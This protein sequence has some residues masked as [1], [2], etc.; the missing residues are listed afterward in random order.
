MRILWSERLWTWLA[1]H[2]WLGSVP[3]MASLLAY[4]LTHG[5]TEAIVAGDSML[6]ALMLTATTMIDLASIQVH[7]PPR[8]ILWSSLI[9]L[10][11]ACGWFMLANQYPSE[12]FDIGVLRS[13]SLWLLLG[14]FV[15]ALG[16][17]IYIETISYKSAGLAK[18]GTS[19]GP[20]AERAVPEPQ[21][22]HEMGADQIPGGPK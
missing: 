7:G 19:V 10:G 3:F 20:S 11:W 5:K 21:V 17:Q 1:V 16:V 22:Q 18:A 8:V 13:M 2:C 9:M 4:T 15:A 6:L 14:T 12:Q